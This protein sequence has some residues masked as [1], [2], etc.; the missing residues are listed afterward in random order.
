MPCYN[1]ILSC[2]SQYHIAITCGELRGY[3]RPETL[4]CARVILPYVIVLPV[5]DPERFTV[6]EQPVLFVGVV[7]YCPP[8]QFDKALAQRLIVEAYNAI[9]AEHPGRPITIASGWSDVGV[10]ALAYR[11]ASR[12][13]WG[14][15]GIASAKIVDF[16][17]YE[18]DQ[19]FIIG[20]NWGDESQRFLEMIDLLLKFGGG[21]QSAREAKEFADQGKPVREYDLPRLA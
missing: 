15:I 5:L 18:V 21:P 3:W 12:R 13:G 16:A 2:I 11:E 1:V 7:G 19:G 8:S 17:R 4:L 20:T 9:E 6:N 14:T 10:L